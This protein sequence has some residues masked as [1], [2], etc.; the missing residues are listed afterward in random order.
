MNRVIKYRISPTGRPQW[1]PPMITSLTR[2]ITLSNGSEDKVLI[3]K[4]FSISL[5]TPNDQLSFPSTDSWLMSSSRFDRQGAFQGQ[6]EAKM[7]RPL[8]QCLEDP[9]SIRLLVS[10]RG[11]A[12]DAAACLDSAVEDDR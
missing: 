4:V 10:L 12:L 3:A 6:I 5:M 7:R 1:V 11:E 2:R 8:S 9:V